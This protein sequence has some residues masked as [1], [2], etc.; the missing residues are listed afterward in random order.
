[1]GS[2][3][4]II[5]AGVLV[6]L[7]LVYRKM[8]KAGSPLFKIGYF[9]YTR[10]SVGYYYYRRE[11]AKAARKYNNESH[12]ITE[13]TLLNGLRILPI[14]MSMDNF[15]YLVTD[16]KSQVSILIDPADPDS[17]QPVLDKE[18][19][20]PTAILTTHKHWDHSG[21]NKEWRRRYRSLRVYGG[22]NDH[23]P[24]CTNP[25][26]DKETISIGNLSFEVNYTPGHTSGHVV[27]LLSGTPFGSPHSLFTGDHL[28]LGGIGRMF[29]GNSRT[30]LESLD[31]VGALPDDTLIW[32]GHEYAVDNL[33]FA[34]HVDP[35]N[36]N[37]QVNIISVNLIKLKILTLTVPLLTCDTNVH[38]LFTGEVTLVS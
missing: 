37:V 31:K 11:V 22:A 18:N 10:T 32:P 26:A 23:V 34:E 17:V 3:G 33:E 4:Y 35:D 7:W 36:E 14:A 29:E 27:Y 24:S 16:T 21:G 12:S 8:A 13:P 2:S 19:I 20:T 38:D 15:C 1:M 28:F 9:L 6:A 30:M 5:S 25:V